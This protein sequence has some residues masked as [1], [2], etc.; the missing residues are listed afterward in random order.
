[1]QRCFY[2]TVFTLFAV[3]FTVAA[4]FVPAMLIPFSLVSTT[5]F[6]FVTALSYTKQSCLCSQAVVALFYIV[7]LIVTKDPVPGLVMLLLF[8]PVGWSVGMACYM[9]RRLNSAGAMSV[10]SGTAFIF[11]IFLVYAVFSTYP[12]ISLTAAGENI[13]DL[14][15]PELESAI[16]S[17]FEIESEITGQTSEYTYIY[18]YESIASFVFS[19]VPTVVG[20]WLLFS[21][22][23]SFW[24]LK[25]VF[26]LFKQDVSFMGE[27]GDFKVSRTGAFIYFLSTVFT[28]T[29]MGTALGTV[30]VN[31]SGVMSVVLAYAGISLISFILEL[32]NVP[33]YLR[34]IIVGVLFLF[35]LMPFGISYILSFV[36]LID[37]YLDIRERFR[38]SGV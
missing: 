14:I 5:L 1:M 18:S 33:D 37:S 3:G 13:R 21:S 2:S 32:K 27:F 17:F 8:F 4:I 22:T 15:I 9:R 35:G 11:V 19:Y 30:A 23:V 29:A 31:F 34:Y 20:V 12:D 38:N 25:A 10:L 28:V 24:L 26:K 6:S 7:T 16:A 36:G